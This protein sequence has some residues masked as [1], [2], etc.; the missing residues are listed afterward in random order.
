M[1]L[2][3]FVFRFLASLT[4][5]KHKMNGKT[6]LYIPSEGFDLAANEAS[7]NKELVQ[8]LESKIGCN[9]KSYVITL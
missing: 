3:F 8:R 2:L 1:K 7:Q 9:V 6:V 5:I 4:D